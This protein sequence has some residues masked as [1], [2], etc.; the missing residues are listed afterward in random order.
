MTFFAGVFNLGLSEHL[1]KDSKAAIEHLRMAAELEPDLA[2]GC[3][4]GYLGQELVDVSR[5]GL[6]KGE[7]D[8]VFKFMIFIFSIQQCSRNGMNSTLRNDMSHRV[9]RLRWNRNTVT[10]S[11]ALSLALRLYVCRPRRGHGR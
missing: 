5:S 1:L 8:T 4:F 7:S 9:Y 3:V 11:L 10:P 6:G 2:G